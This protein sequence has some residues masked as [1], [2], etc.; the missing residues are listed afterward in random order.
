MRKF[1]GFQPNYSYTSPKFHALWNL[2][3]AGWGSNTGQEHFPSPPGDKP[4]GYS[5]EAA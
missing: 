2:G 3:E 5:C 4:P 1:L